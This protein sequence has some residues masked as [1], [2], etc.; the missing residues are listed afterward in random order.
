MMTLH[1][2]APTRPD[3][4]L[5]DPVQPDP[6]LTAPDA[7][8]VVQWQGRATPWQAWGGPG[9]GDR[10]ALLLLGDAPAAL[11]A[12]LRPEH[13]CALQPGRQVLCFAS[14]L[15]H[16][17][18]PLLTADALECALDELAE[19]RRQLHLDCVHL[20]ACGWGVQVAVEHVLMGTPGV[21]SLI[22]SADGPSLPAPGNRLASLTVPT[23]VLAAPSAPSAAPA[24][25]TQAQA[26]HGAI[27]WSELLLDTDGDATGSTT[28]PHAAALEDFL[29]R[30]EAY[31]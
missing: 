17:A 10:P 2:S 26:L 27:P 3:P 8:G 9:D 14:A 4:A 28:I 21:A 29:E 12:L 23:L 25:A 16:Q 5:P 24:A 30:V 19:L 18:A 1:E 20:V 7:G 15:G 31:H 11:P 22:L 13:L 6:A